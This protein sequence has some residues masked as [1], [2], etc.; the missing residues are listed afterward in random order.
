MSLPSGLMIAIA[1]SGACV[2]EHGP[3]MTMEWVRCARPSR[4]DRITYMLNVN[5]PLP[6]DVYDSL[7]R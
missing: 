6:D 5:T 2:G 3:H 4:S 7:M 1:C